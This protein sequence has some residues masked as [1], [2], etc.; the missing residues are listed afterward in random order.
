MVSDHCFSSSSDTN[1]IAEHLDKSL[2]DSATS[3][4]LV[5]LAS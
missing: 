4:N 2:N 1:L 5:E 3:I